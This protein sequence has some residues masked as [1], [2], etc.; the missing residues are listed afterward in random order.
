M[1]LLN[2]LKNKF[3]ASGDTIWNEVSDD[4]NL[5]EVL[6]NSEER[7]QLIYKHSYRCSVCFFAKAQIEKKSEEISKLADLHFLNVITHREASNNIASKLNVRHES[8]QA[9]LMHKGEV[10]WHASHGK[11]KGEAVLSELKSHKGTPSDG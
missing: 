4:F 1:G 2:S 5:Y 11:I 6:A 7:S 9:I 3:S 8:P 10:I